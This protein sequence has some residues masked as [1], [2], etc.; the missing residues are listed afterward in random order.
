[1]KLRAHEP[2]F[3][4]RKLLIRIADAFKAAIFPTRCLVCRS[5]FQTEKSEGVRDTYEDMRDILSSF[6]CPAGNPSGGPVIA[7]NFFGRCFRILFAPFLCPTC[8]SGFDALESPLCITCGLKF[9]SREGD[10]HFCGE[11]LTKPKRFQM[12]RATGIYSRTLMKLIHR[13]KYGRKTNLAA[14]LGVLLFI[15]LIRYWDVNTIDLVL[16]VPLH[17]RRLRKRGFNQAFLLIR[18]WYRIAAELKISLANIQMKFDVLTRNRWTQSQTGLARKERMANIKNAFS[19]NDPLK[20]EDKRILLVDDVYTTGATVDECAQVLL[21][22]GA[23][24]VD[25]LTLARAL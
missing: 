6:F 15:A 23:Q 17:V 25:V 4:A 14:P 24:T 13:Y 16:P 22:G 18:D 20:I 11:C 10:D 19:I 5:F 21:A 9:I 1:M 2:N 3:E 8:L 12:A 7:D